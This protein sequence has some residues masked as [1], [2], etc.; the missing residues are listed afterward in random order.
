[1]MR[2]SLMLFL[3]LAGSQVPAIAADTA[4]P[5]GAYKAAQSEAA[6]R[7]ASD[8]KLCAEE[9][10]AASRMQCLRD[11]KAVHDK[12]LADAKQRL[13]A[14]VKPA[15]GAATCADCGQVVGVLMAT[16]KG[17]G[18]ALG[19]IGGGVAGALLGHQVGAG[20]GKDVATV[21]GAAGGAYGGYKAEEKL[22]STKTWS[23]TVKMDSGEQRVVEFDHEPGVKSGDL[24]KVSGNTITRR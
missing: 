2:P 10:N 16:K 24:V 5:E 3:L 1:M 17:K 23:V 11:A 14:E 15:Q 19:A 22:R 7:Y 8:K 4:A 9:S 18:G 12:A 20:R 13:G 6:S 21:A